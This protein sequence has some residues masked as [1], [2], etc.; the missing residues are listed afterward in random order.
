[1]ITGKVERVDLIS[2]IS[3]G[4]DYC[5]I[6]ID[7][8]ELKIFGDYNEI[9]SYIGKDVIYET[10]PDMYQGVII[11][12]IINF[13]CKQIIQAVDKVESIKLIPKDTTTRVICNFSVDAL[14]RGD[15]EVNC[16]ALFCDYEKGASDKTT[17]VDLQMIDKNAKIFTLRMFTNKV[18]GNIDS[19]EVLN[20]LKGHYVKFNANYTKYGIQTDFVELLNIPVVAPPE[21][22]VAITQIQEFIKD[23]IALQSYITQFNYLEILESILYGEPGYHIVELAM[24]L[25]LINTLSD[26]SC[27]YDIP[28]L[29]R[30]AITSRGYLLP[31]KTKFSKVLLNTNKVLKSE[32][33]TDRSLLLILDTMSEDEADS[34]NKSAFY[35]IQKFCKQTLDERRGIKREEEYNIYSHSLGYRM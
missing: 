3:T 13:Y 9:L 5:S 18:E 14:R 11:T 6:L 28:L 16:I 34:I 1:M 22:A 35:R 26:I 2:H 31:S 23:D 10:A 7:F 30:A 20:G 12:R 29:I 21:V 25:Y 24:E 19:N 32:L 4:L 8:D 33:R 27:E 15:F 17:W